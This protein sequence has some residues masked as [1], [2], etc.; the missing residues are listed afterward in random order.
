[1]IVDYRKAFEFPFKDSDWQKKVLIGG[2]FYFAYYLIYYAC[3][4]AIHFNALIKAHA[5]LQSPNAH[6]PIDNI[7]IIIISMIISPLMMIPTG[8][9]LESAHNEINKIDNLM[10][11]WEQNYLSY[12]KKGFW[13]AYL[14]AIIY[15]IPSIIV[16]LIIV[17]PSAILFPAFSKVLI[18]ALFLIFIL[19]YILFLAIYPFISLSCAEKF[20][21]K[22]G[23]NIPRI[24]KLLSKVGG[25]YFLNLL[26]IFALGIAF[27]ILVLL[28]TCTCVG[29]ILVPFV[30]FLYMLIFN[31]IFAQI[32]KSA[33]SKMNS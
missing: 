10:P 15:I 7:I 16:M 1:M 19:F 12:L 32:Y 31:N 18:P 23:L 3:S 8:Y 33:L 30:S 20:R 21:L 14:P 22:D 6:N 24:F 9:T 2:A 25:E 13:I 29:I 11:K 4:F 28:L 26:F 5:G 27:V 17:I